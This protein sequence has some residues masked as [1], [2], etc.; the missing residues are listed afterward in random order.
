[1]DHPLNL[2]SSA[3]FPRVP[4]SPR[5]RVSVLLIFIDGVGIGRRG[6]HN[7]LYGLE[8]EFF[9]IFADEEAPLSFDGRMA[10]TDA[11]LGIDGLPQSATGQTTMLTGVNAAALIGRH[12]HGYPSPRF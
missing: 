1:M 8:S 2:S 6:A 4:A 12:L 3:V 11:R 10:V 9:S 7:P 5:P